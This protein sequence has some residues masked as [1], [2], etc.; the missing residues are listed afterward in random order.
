MENNDE[1]SIQKNEHKKSIKKKRHGCLADTL[2]ALVIGIVFLFSSCTVILNY[3]FPPA[4]S[5]W[6]VEKILNKNKDDI[7]TAIKDGSIQYSK[8]D[9]VTDISEYDFNS[10]VVFFCGS[11]DLENANSGFY[12]SK[13]DKPEVRFGY[14]DKLEETGYNCWEYDND[15]YSYKT[16]KICDNFYYFYESF[17]YDDD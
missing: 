5:K 9:G 6:K 8:I 17:R 3:M 11:S 15:D 13:E 16:K 1:T 14:P 10:A 2:L 4:P 12:Y 7:L